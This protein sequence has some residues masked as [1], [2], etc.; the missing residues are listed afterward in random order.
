MKVYVYREAN[1]YDAFN[2]ELIVVFAK[3]EDAVAF[4]KNSVENSFGEPWERCVEI[5]EEEDGAIWPTYVEYPTGCGYD[6]YSVTEYTVKG[7]KE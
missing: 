6:F 4:L 5:V 1:D 3:K 2:A 7:G